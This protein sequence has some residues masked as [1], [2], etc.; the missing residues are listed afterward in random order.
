M[1]V[2]WKAKIAI[3]NVYSLVHIWLATV[4]GTLRVDCM[5]VNLPHIYFKGEE[6]Y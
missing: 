5:S 3:W 6:V 1:I 4:R 2:E